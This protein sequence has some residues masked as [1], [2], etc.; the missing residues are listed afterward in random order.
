MSEYSCTICERVVTYEGPPPPDYP[1]CSE[2][3]R[4]VDLD[5]WF[6]ERYTID[7]DMTGEDLLDPDMPTFNHDPDSSPE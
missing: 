3:C 5:N 4:L 7:R 6:R 2:R 1:F